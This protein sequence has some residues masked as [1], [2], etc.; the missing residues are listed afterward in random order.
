MKQFLRSFLTLLML[1]VWCSVGLAQDKVSVSTLDKSAAKTKTT[2]DCNAIWSYKDAE[3]QQ[4]KGTQFLKFNGDLNVSLSEKN[5]IITKIVINAAQSGTIGK[6]N[7]TINIKV[8]GKSFGEKATLST[9]DSKDYSFEGESSGNIV[10][11]LGSSTNNAS[12]YIKT[13]SFTYHLASSKTPTTLTFPKPTI[14]IVEGNEATFTG[15]TAILKTGETELGNAIT[16]TT[17]NNAM[18][19][20]YDAKVGPKTLKTGAYGTA[21]VTAKFNGDDTYEASTATYTVNYTEK[22]KPATTLDFGFT[23]K[24]VNIDETFTAAATLKSGETAITGAVTYSSTNTK[25]ATVDKA[26]GE[27]TALTAG[28][29]TITATFAGTSE[30]KSSTATYELTVVDPNLIILDESTDKGTISTDQGQNDAIEKGNIVLKGYNIALN[31]KN[32]SYYKIYSKGYFTIS[33]KEGII[34][35]IAINCTGSDTNDYGP[36]HL[37]SDTEGYSYAGKVG[38]WEGNATSVK[39]TNTDT[40]QV[41]IKSIEITVKNKVITLDENLNNTFSEEKGVTVKTVRTLVANKWNTFCVPFETEIAGTALEGATVKAIGTVVGNVINLVDATKIEAGVPYLVMP[42]TES[43]VNPT[44]KN[45]TIS[46]TT[47]IEKG[48]A[49]YKFVG[50]YS[51]KTIAEGEFGKIWGVTAEGK[52]AKIKTNTTMKG[53]RAYFVFPTNAAAAKL[54]FDGETTGI[55]NI[56]TNAAVNGKVYNLNGQYVGNSLNG[57]KK[58]IYVVNGKKV[59]K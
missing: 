57:L 40:K 15:Q 6:D 31:A 34:T 4:T 39:I 12:I 55:N 47:P 16:Y 7:K 44:F 36:G 24:T 19:E 32:T 21:I 13:V 18:F 25:V 41:R 26:T 30:Y 20:A 14:N 45:V 23:T 58:G 2:G 1:V 17:N 3:A 52:L 37:S 46:V 38:T 10:I 29:T 59:I 35:K 42:N 8:G 22:E 5:A 56:E 51:P 53:L 54:N 27:V 9:K 11:T 49:E 48:N 33:A 28:K 43:I 50:T